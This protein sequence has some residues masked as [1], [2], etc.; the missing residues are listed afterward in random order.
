MGPLPLLL[1][2]QGRAARRGGAPPEGELLALLAEAVGRHLHA[3][4]GGHQPQRLG[5]R[6]RQRHHL[7][8]KRLALP[9]APAER[10]RGRG[11]GGTVTITSGAPVAG[12]QQPASASHLRQA[13]ACWRQR[14]TP[15]QPPT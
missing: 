13:G 8:G 3:A 14:A 6:L 11:V 7:P 12:A 15:Q 10:T 1:L 5:R 4:P 2:P 9:L